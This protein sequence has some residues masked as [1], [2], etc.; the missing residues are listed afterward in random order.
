MDSFISRT[1]DSSFL[2]ESDL[3]SDKK[4]K[5]FSNLDIDYNTEVNDSS[6]ISLSDSLDVS[7]KNINVLSWENIIV[8]N[9]K[10]KNLINLFEAKQTSNEKLNSNTNKTD[11]YFIN[12]KISLETQSNGS[13]SSSSKTSLDVPQNR[14]ILNQGFNS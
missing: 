12:S 4:T 9:K 6:R 2:A 10:R 8:F 14:Q 1:S 5:F 3:T 13:A 7:F 11:K